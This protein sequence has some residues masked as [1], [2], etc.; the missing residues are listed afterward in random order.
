MYNQENQ[1]MKELTTQQIY[2]QLGVG[3]QLNQK[4][5][6]MDNFVSYFLFHLLL[7]TFLIIELF[8]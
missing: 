3:D 4:I 2:E 6:E 5:P 1:Q 7:L 8:K